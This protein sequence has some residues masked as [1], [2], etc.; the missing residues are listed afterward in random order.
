M[1]NPNELGSGGG[2]WGSSGNFAGN[3]GGLVRITAGDIIL[4][5][6]IKANGGGG[7]QTGNGGGSGGGVYIQTGILS[8]TG[9]ITASG[10][11]NSTAYNNAIGGGGGRIAIYYDDL[12]GFDT[13]NITAYGGVAFGNGGAGTIYLKDQINQVYGDL[14][15]DNNN[16]ATTG[17]ST[18][19]PSVATGT[20]TGL[21]ADTLTDTNRSW[22]ANNL[23]GIYL[24]PNKNQSSVFQIISNDNTTITTDLNDGNMTTVAAIGDTYRGKHIFDYFDIKGLAGVETGDDIKVLNPNT[25]NGLEITGSLKS[26]SLETNNFPVIVNSGGLTVNDFISGGVSEITITNADIL[27]YNTLNVTTLNLDNSTY[28]GSGITADTITLNNNS[29]VSHPS[30]TTGSEYRLE[31]NVTNTLSIDSTSSIDV[32]EKG[33][34]GSYRNGNNDRY[35]RTI[36]NTTTG[37][38]FIASGGSYGGMGGQYESEN[39]NSVYG[40]LYNPNECQRVRV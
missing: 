17:Y 26:N 30:A 16:I 21:T 20:S 13:G 33:Y 38:S 1:Y 35:G 4:D 19:L 5:G 8:G 27:N 39:V 2:G 15:V 11:N 14:I 32:T 12:S 3:G 37:G 34:L 25:L 18:P 24:N 22:R 6:S 9:M 29:Q 31:I 28:T 7:A 40:S 23:V 10:G 36:G